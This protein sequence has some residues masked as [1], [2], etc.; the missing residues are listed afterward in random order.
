MAQWLKHTH[1]KQSVGH[2]NPCSHW[3]WSYNHNFSG[4]KIKPEDLW[5][6]LIR[7]MSLCYR[8]PDSMNKIGNN[9][10]QY[11]QL[12]ASTYTQ[13]Y[14]YLHIYLHPHTRKHTETHV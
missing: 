8:D 9:G 14:V 11:L 4:W 13:M 7:L 3:V 12:Q 2:Q 5:H 10:E 1:R 6:K